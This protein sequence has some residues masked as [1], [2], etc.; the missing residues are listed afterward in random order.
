MPG[1]MGERSQAGSNESLVPD[2]NSMNPKQL[3]EEARRVTTKAEIGRLYTFLAARLTDP[4]RA[5]R[6]MTLATLQHLSAQREKLAA[7][8]ARNDDMVFEGTNT[9]ITKYSTEESLPKEEADR[10]FQ[11]IV[12]I[13]EG[14]TRH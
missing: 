5:D 1:E 10:I 9:R 11:E 2:Y 4:S 8:P 6:D 7:A 13:S 12:D 14:K 3:I